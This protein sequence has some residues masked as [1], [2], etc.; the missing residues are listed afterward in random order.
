MP[1]RRIPE[2]KVEYFRSD[3]RRV[4]QKCRC[5]IELGEMYGLYRQARRRVIPLCRACAAVEYLSEQ[6]ERQQG[7]TD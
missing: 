1:K 2:G 4:C 3:R 7:H 5:T 6:T